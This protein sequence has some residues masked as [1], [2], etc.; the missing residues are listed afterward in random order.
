M[1]FDLFLQA[2]W[3]ALVLLACWGYARRLFGPANY[4]MPTGFSIF[5]IIFVAFR[6]THLPSGGATVCLILFCLSGWVFAVIHLMRFPHERS[7]VIGHLSAFVAIYTLGYLVPMSA[8]VD[9]KHYAMDMAWYFSPHW[10]KEQ[11]AHMTTFAPLLWD[12]ASLSRPATT[13]LGWT[14]N[15]ISISIDHGVTFRLDLVLLVYLG[16]LIW[17]SLAET[18]T[19][20]RVAIVI[21][22][23]GGNLIFSLLFLG[24]L[25]Q[26]FGSVF[27]IMVFLL[28]RDDTERRISRLIQLSLVSCTF[29]LSYPEMC[30]LLP[31]AA[32]S[33]FLLRKESTPR[34]LALERLGA[35]AAGAGLPLIVRLP[36]YLEY[37]RHQVAYRVE[38]IPFPQ[39]TKNAAYYWGI[40]LAGAENKY[41]IVGMLFSIFVLWAVRF[42]VLDFRGRM[43]L[44]LAVVWFG[45]YSAVCIFFVDI[46]KTPPYVLFKLACWVGPLVPL[47]LYV[48][49]SDSRRESAKWR[50]TLERCTVGVFV[51]IAAISLYSTFGRLET[52]SAGERQFPVI[53]VH[54]AETNRVKPTDDQSFYSMEWVRM[55]LPYHDRSIGVAEGLK[56]G[57]VYAFTIDGN[58]KGI[59][60]TGWSA[61]EQWHT[62]TGADKAVLNI[63]LPPVEADVYLGMGCNAYTNPPRVPLQR[64][65][66]RANDQPVDDFEVKSYFRRVVKIPRAIAA[67]RKS[68]TVTILLPDATATPDGRELGIGCNYMVINQGT[69][70]TLW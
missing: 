56:W 28:V 61:P 11:A 58:A 29:V 25:G 16:Y 40:I 55:L 41:V 15:L 30:L 52:I 6:W 3:F 39:F 1:S 59:E 64:I 14:S 68:L 42:T 62:W 26:G 47:M 45:A 50:V 54:D 7:S 51:A 65:L 57:H 23:V 46:A 60:L 43:R 13:I 35:I 10:A 31:F 20:L 21:S 70:P 67:E 53:A 17:V 66:F 24:Q 36:S 48:T 9:Q 5:A 12:I 4:L 34:A 33:G 2:C 32:A 69:P 19:F 8:A 18:A 49:L 22:A 27:L 37:L 63:P 44:G 38:A